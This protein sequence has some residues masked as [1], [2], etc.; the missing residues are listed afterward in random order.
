MEMIGIYIMTT[1]MV[2]L[3][4]QEGVNSGRYIGTSVTYYE[5]FDYIDDDENDDKDFIYS[6]GRYLDDAPSDFGK[7]DAKI[8]LTYYRLTKVDHIDKYDLQVTGLDVTMYIEPSYSFF[9]KPYLK[10]GVGLSRQKY[11]D[12]ITYNVDETDGLFD[13]FL[14]ATFGIGLSA[15]FY[16]WLEVYGGYEYR[17]YILDEEY[18]D[19][20]LD[21]VYGVEVGARIKF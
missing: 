15:D 19:I 17:Y 10:Y 9:I 7:L 8:E 14:N 4:A 12:N 18:E 5:D 16:N 3:P 20:F 13:G 6:I 21:E 11:I 2:I 1:G